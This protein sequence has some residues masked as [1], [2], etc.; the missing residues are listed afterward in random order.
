M[1]ILITGATGLIGQALIKALKS[2][3]Q[4]AFVGRDIKKIN[5]AFS[6]FSYQAYNWDDLTTQGEQILA[7]TDVVI[8]LAG[9]NIGAK[10]WTAK[11]KRKILQSRFN[12]TKLIAQ[13]AVESNNPHLRILN[14]SAVGIYGF[15]GDTEA[16]QKTVFDEQTHLA[17]NPDSFLA[18]VGKSWEQ[19]LKPV[20]DAAQVSVTRM[21]FGVVL[22]SQGGALAKLLPAFRF[23][24]GAVLGDGK[25]P[26]TWIALDDLV[27]AIGFIIDHPEMTGAINLTA[28]DVVS[29]KEF[30]DTLASVIGR[31]RFMVMPSYVV[32]LLF[33]EMGEELLLN[34]QKVSCRRLLDAGFQFKYPTLREA[35]TH[36]LRV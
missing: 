33:G 16:Q 4:L 7:K 14:A 17:D 9:E 31:P 26:F 5:Q 24:L 21:R 1:K 10:Y 11:Q 3:H 32:R 12:V 19:A 36:E 27:S 20:E 13:K 18:E 8:N 23:G 29:Q 6:G 28:P 30:A 25:Q 34:G 15:A 35:L 2:T 22:A